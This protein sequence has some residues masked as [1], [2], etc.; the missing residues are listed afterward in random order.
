MLCDCRAE[1]LEL[2]DV[3][4]LTVP[5]YGI[6]DKTMEVVG[7][8]IGTQSPVQLTL[9]EITQEIFDPVSELTGRDPAPDSS[10]R[11]PR[12]V[13]SLGALTVTSAS[14]ADGTNATRTLVSW[15]A[16]TGEWIRNGGLIEIQFTRADQALPDGD[17][18]SQT[19]PGNSV[20]TVIYGLLANR[21]YLFRGRLRTISPPVSGPW[22]AP[23]QEFVGI[24]GAVDVLQDNVTP[25]P[26]N[27]HTEILT[28]PYVAAATGNATVSAQ[29]QIRYLNSA[30]GLNANGVL[31]L[32]PYNGGVGTDIVSSSTPQV[33]PLQ[34][35]V[36]AMSLSGT[37]A[38]TSGNSY[39]FSLIGARRDAA[40]TF[41]VWDYRVTVTPP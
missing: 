3:V 39:E 20:S 8:T 12:A 26:W 19:E 15:P 22:G 32:R 16:V 33:S 34:V 7:L 25:A 2:F 36:A 37:Y 14:E 24:G 10:L 30:T 9:R 31:K 41:E 17:W 1:V 18:Q 35:V 5:G 23:V 6:E 40:D 29:A 28:V 13:G 11:D 27:S 21:P 4:T 38:V